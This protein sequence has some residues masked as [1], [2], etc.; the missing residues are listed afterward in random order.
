MS[1]RSPGSR[2]SGSWFAERT[3]FQALSEHDVRRVARPEIDLRQLRPAVL[4]VEVARLA[5]AAL[6]REHGAVMGLARQELREE[7][8]ADAHALARRDDVELDHLE[9]RRVEAPLAPG[10][11]Q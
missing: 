5:G 3:K 8:R 4:R 11:G 10:V 7:A 6:G 1:P 2:N 9:V